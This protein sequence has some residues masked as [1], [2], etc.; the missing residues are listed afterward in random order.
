MY[1]G[2]YNKTYKASLEDASKIILKRPYKVG[3]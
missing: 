1:I 3:V 2:T